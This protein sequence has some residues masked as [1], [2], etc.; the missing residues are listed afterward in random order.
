[1]PRVRRFQPRTS[2]LFLMF[3]SDRARE[4]SQDYQPCLQL[5]NELLRRKCMGEPYILLYNIAVCEYRLNLQDCALFHFSKS[6]RAK[7]GFWPSTLNYSLLLSRSSRVEEAHEVVDIFLKYYPSQYQMELQY[8]ATSTKDHY[9]T[10]T[11]RYR[12]KRLHYEVL[13]NLAV[14]LKRIGKG[15]E[16]EGY[17]RSLEGNH[18]AGLLANKAKL[19]RGKIYEENRM[20]QEAIEVYQ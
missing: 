19:I 13:W 17:L 16:A 18:R 9:H 15:L 14:Y 3:S 4:Y 10:I 11:K 12:G 1:M 6:L 7:P 5:Y 20:H 8:I 2:L